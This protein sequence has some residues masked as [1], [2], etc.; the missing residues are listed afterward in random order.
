MVVSKKENPD[1]L[2]GEHYCLLVHD[3]RGH[4]FSH[5][6]PIKGM[7]ESCAKDS[8]VTSLTKEMINKGGHLPIL[9]ETNCA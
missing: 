3:K 6:D 4:T 5:M 7:N 1:E 8:Y 2:E 9:V